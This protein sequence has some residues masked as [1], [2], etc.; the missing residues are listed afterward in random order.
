MAS[1]KKKQQSK[2]AEAVNENIATSEKP[3]NT[4]HYDI[5]VEMI[6]NQSKYDVNEIL[7]LQRL[8]P[9]SDK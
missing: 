4:T 2:P 8:T 5:P 1:K 3:E 6:A 7:V 9:K